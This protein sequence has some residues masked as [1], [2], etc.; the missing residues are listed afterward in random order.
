MDLLESELV[1]ALADPDAGR[2]T[3]A[4]SGRLSLPLR[5]AYMP[6]VAHALDLRG[7][8]CAGG[9]VALLAAARPAGLDGRTQPDYA[10]LVQ[11]RSSRVL[12][13]VGKFAVVPK[14]FHEPAVEPAGEVQL[15]ASLRRELEEELLGRRS[16]AAC[17][18]TASAR[19]TR[20]TS[21]CSALRC[22]GC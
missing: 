18:P 15:S 2:T 5:N 21:T 13:A 1:H 20:F 17:S 4:G 7:R 12:N 16:L 10:L 8:V 11:E 14:A 3:P 9:V 6:S 22:A 19:S